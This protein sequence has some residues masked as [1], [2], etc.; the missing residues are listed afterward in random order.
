[1]QRQK[2]ISRAGGPDLS[3]HALLSDWVNS[4]GCAHA[5]VHNLRLAGESVLIRQLSH[6]ISSRQDV[7]SK[8]I[9][10]HTFPQ[11]VQGQRFGYEAHS[12]FEECDRN[13]PI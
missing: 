13:C 11:R 6:D 8:P 2:W 9:R 5:H 1:M 7:E 4:V 3:V 10:S 12:L